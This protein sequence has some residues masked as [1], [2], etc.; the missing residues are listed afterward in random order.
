ME[1]W[2]EGRA[3]VLADRDVLQQAQTELQALTASLDAAR[4]GLT[5]MAAVLAFPT[6]TE[7][8]LAALF[9]SVE[10]AI[11]GLE[12]KAEAW[13]AAGQHCEQSREAAKLAE[14]QHIDAQSATDIWRGRWGAAMPLLGLDPAAELEEAEAALDVW[15]E[16]QGHQKGL[17]DL[18]HR[19]RR[20]EEDARIF[21][22]HVRPLAADLA[23]ALAETDPVALADRL[24]QDLQVARKAEAERTRLMGDLTKARAERDRAG[25]CREAAK[26][27]LAALRTIAGDAAADGLDGL[28]DKAARKRRL[29]DEID[30]ARAELVKAGGGAD[31]AALREEAAEADPDALHGQDQAL[32][33]E[34]TDLAG[35]LEE[36]GQALARCRS[37]ADRLDR[38][39][40]A[41]QAA[42]DLQDA[43]TD[44]RRHA[45]DWARHRVAAVLL[46][47]AVERFRE[48][49]QH[50]LLQRAGQVFAQ[51][52]VGSFARLAVDY[53]DKDEPRLVGERPGDNGT[54]GERLV[55]TAMSDGTR[56]QLYLALRIA[57]IEHYCR[58]AEPLPF[59]GDDLF[60]NFD[61]D[62]AAAGLAALAPQIGEG[63]CQ[64]ILFTHHV[65][66]VEL[67][68]THLGARVSVL[69][70]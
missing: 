1:V 23:P 22:D 57:T 50:P 13:R 16:V 38:H 2:L 49:N 45:A 3:R 70:L 55:V 56:D 20:I 11:E 62:R 51:L 7:A 59:I 29:A 25:E 4:S 39:G 35:A 27:E 36:A 67:A 33:T 52:T 19:I 34:L 53:D 40:G 43:L 15:N 9:G 60:I 30:A 21:D 18:D 37:E 8:D 69:D 41:A 5:G 68:R 48:E 65:H 24:F 44:V 64:V 28:A 14:S 10:A 66:L 61:D 47:T 26:S 6:D 12:A 32:Q 63:P 46:K 31:E 17:A 42:Q 54:P 58:Q